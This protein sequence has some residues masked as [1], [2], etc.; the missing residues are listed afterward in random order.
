M[1]SEEVRSL[2]YKV[3]KACAASMNKKEIQDL[4]EILARIEYSYCNKPI[5]SMQCST[6]IKNI[7]NELFVNKHYSAVLLPLEAEIIEKDA[8]QGFK[9]LYSVVCG[10]RLKYIGSKA[11]SDCENLAMVIIPQDC[12]YEEDSFPEGCV[13]ITNTDKCLDKKLVVRR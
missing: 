9:Q 7:N 11:F 5:L 4:T 10:R 12:D 13:V 6:G 3:L 2:N 1:E 8:F